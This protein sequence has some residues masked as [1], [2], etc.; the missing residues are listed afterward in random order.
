MSKTME[1]PKM[2]SPRFFATSCHTQV[3]PVVMGQ[4]P[5]LTGGGYRWMVI[6]LTV[7]VLSA[8]DRKADPPPETGKRLLEGYQPA[9]VDSITVSGSQG[10]VELVRDGDGWLVRERA[11]M[12]ADAALVQQ[13]VLDAWQMAAVQQI[14]AEPQHYTRLQVAD[15]AEGGEGVRVLLKSGAREDACVL[16]KAFTGPPRDGKPGSTLGRVVRLGDMVVVT[17]RLFRGVVPA[18]AA[19]LDRRLDGFGNIIALE[20][21]GGSEAWKVERRDG[22]WVPVDFPAD[23]HFNP[24]PVASAANLWRQPVFQDIAEPSAVPD[25]EEQ[26]IVTLQDGAWVRLSRGPQSQGYVPV[27]IER[28]TGEQT[29]DTGHYLLPPALVEA[30]FLQQEELRVPDGVD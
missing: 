25:G 29:E 2:P 13:L 9:A 7:L 6:A 17:D 20:R 19:F 5:Y 4:R 27:K 22:G 12:E 8:C 11:G 24:A 3:C 21:A 23:F 30:I 26:M 15:P 28:G 14:P 18:P 16:G 10:S 1:S